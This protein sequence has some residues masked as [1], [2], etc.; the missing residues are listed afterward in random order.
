MTPVADLVDSLRSAVN[1]LRLPSS[2]SVVLYGSA[3]EVNEGLAPRDIDLWLDGDDLE[4]IE[5][6]RAR[7]RHVV[8][9]GLDVVTPERLQSRPAAL[10][11]ACQW[12][13]SRGAVIAGRP[14]ARPRIVWSDVLDA[15]QAAALTSTA[16]TAHNSMVLAR[17]GRGDTAAQ[18][19]EHA[20][21]D[22]L[23]GCSTE[24]SQWRRARRIQRSD[25]QAAVR[26]VSP[27]LAT[28][29]EAD[30]WGSFDVASE[31]AAAAIRAGG[32]TIES[33]AS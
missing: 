5:L 28:A 17:I 30:G 7:L 21:R 32:R 15:Y 4:S 6:A 2:V 26:V 8:S 27:A 19:S 1:R 3:L 18:L 12:T 33:H 22:L 10:K 16:V 14:P 24:P 29:V 13:A 23:R 31:I 20:A 11:D 25:L 9:V